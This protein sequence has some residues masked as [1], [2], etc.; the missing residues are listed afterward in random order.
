[1]KVI[2]VENEMKDK[3]LLSSHLLLYGISMLCFTEFLLI[4]FWKWVLFCRR[5]FSSR[6]VRRARYLSNEERGNQGGNDGHEL[7]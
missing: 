2:E 6:P 3:I 7:A 5:V 1:M 4:F